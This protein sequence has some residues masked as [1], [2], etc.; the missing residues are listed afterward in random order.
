MATKKDLVEAYS[1]SRRRLVTAFV[2]GAPGGR[3]VEP[4][5]PGRMIVGGVAL[6]ILLIA[7]AAVAGA[8]TKRPTVDWDSPGLVTDDHGALYVI[9]DEEQSQGQE[10]LRPV[11]N[12]T[13]AQLILGADVKTK[14]VPDDVL[15]ERKKGP[16]IGILDAPPTVPG[17]GNLLNSG[18]VSC[19]A[20]GKGVQTEVRP[21][22]SV[23]ETPELGFVV[24]GEPSGKRYLIAQAEVPGHP[25]RA[26]SYAAPA[27]PDG[28]YA[29]LKVEASDEIV[30]PDAWLGLFPTGGALTEAGLGFDDWGQRVPLP[31]YTTAR[32]GD[33]Y[34]RSGQFYAVTKK[35]FVQLSEFAFA[36]LRSTPIGDD[37]PRPI[38]Q[39]GEGGAF[40][41]VAAP[42]DASSWPEDAIAGGSA[43]RT[44]TV[45]GV[46][47][48]GEDEEPAVLLATF[49]SGS[50]MI[51]D[52]SAGQSN[53]SVEAGY[54]AVVRSADWDTSSGGTVHLVDDGGRSYSIAGM[55][56]VDNL[57]YGR[58]PEVVVP[59]T[60]L[61]LF[62]PGPDLSLLDAL[63]PPRTPS[64]DVGDSVG[65]ACA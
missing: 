62:T 60:W 48:T 61:Q 5:R 1:F 33:Y 27:N 46:L 41:V 20:T 47:K 3:E 42:Y 11:I 65:P 10:Q 55:T 38:K 16:S 50:A 28:L 51:G 56:E 29:D 25:V 14:S 35:G 52:V 36:V 43:R 54:G 58:V 17:A 63:C 53:V 7:G 64:E 40:K 45:C 19:T 39:V 26:Y 34:E 49:P 44:D 21:G 22:R 8:L 37:M 13:S 57:G 59:S 31:G 6:A 30:V 24:R 12:V 32:V 2:S 23:Q 18:W 9:L 15:A 4:A